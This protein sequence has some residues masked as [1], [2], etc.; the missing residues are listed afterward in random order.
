MAQLVPIHSFGADLFR[1]HEQMGVAGWLAWHGSR[2]AAVNLVRQRF[3]GHHNSPSAII[4]A[5][6]SL[7]CP[8]VVGAPVEQGPL[9]ILQRTVPHGVVYAC[10]PLEV[11]HPWAWA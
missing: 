2:L 7:S 3:A 6:V 10:A 5:Y 11:P 4:W 9:S 1:D 8:L